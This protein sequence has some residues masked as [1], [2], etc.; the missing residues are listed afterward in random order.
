[1]QPPDGPWVRRGCSHFRPRRAHRCARVVTEHLSTCEEFTAVSH[2]VIPRDCAVTV[3]GNRNPARPR[4]VGETNPAN[5]EDILRMPK[6][7]TLAA[8]AAAVEAGRRYARKQPGPGRQVRGPGRRFRRQAD[9]GQVL[10]PDP[11]RGRQGQDRRGP[12]AHHHPGLRHERRLRQAP[13][14]R[15]RRRAAP[16]PLATTTAP[17]TD[18]VDRPPPRPRGRRSTPSAPSSSPSRAARTSDRRTAGAAPPPPTRTAVVP[19]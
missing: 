18:P 14:L 9:Q 13:G 11:R 2:T 5:T 8:L 4:G 7:K 19:R 10:G 16:D 17:S 3:G 15:L 1:M 12:A 6:L